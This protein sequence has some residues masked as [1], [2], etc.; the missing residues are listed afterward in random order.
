MST[1]FSRWP[2]RRLSVGT[3]YLDMSR[4]C[5]HVT[6][7]VTLQFPSPRGGDLVWRSVSEWRSHCVRGRAKIPDV[8]PF[9][10]T[11]FMT[12]IIHSIHEILDIH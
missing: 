2:P 1:N 5:M 10:V 12:N 11:S 8:S 6:V 7:N 9:C 4:L 3:E